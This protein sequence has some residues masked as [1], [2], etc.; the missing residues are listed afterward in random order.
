MMSALFHDT[1][2]RNPKLCGTEF[3]INDLNHGSLSARINERFI[4]RQDHSKFDIS[5]DHVISLT[6]SH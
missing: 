2:N 4:L 5:S 1:H 3:F 6:L